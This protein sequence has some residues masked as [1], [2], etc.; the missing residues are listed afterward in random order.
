[1]RLDAGWLHN[2]IPGEPAIRHIPSSRTSKLQTTKPLAVVWH[3]TGGVAPDQAE[4]LA[5]RIRTYDRKTDRPASW[6]LIL[7]RS[8]EIWQS[9]PLSRATWHV[10]RPG[11]I[12]GKQYA[13]INRV[14]I[15]V[16]LENAGRLKRIGRDYYCWPYWLNPEDEP[17]DRKPNP[18]LIV[19]VARAARFPGVGVF[20]TFT[21]LQEETAIRLLQLCVKE[22]GWD[23]QACSYGHANFDSP[24]KEDPG[25]A[26]TMESLPKI[27]TKVFPA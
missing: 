16:E 22:Y 26:W 20:E 15:G 1:M 7:A 2:D 23:R 17:E 14:T 27:L 5:K 25:P 4:S 12:L 11:K 9:A 6:H 3:Y 8:G 21:T 18:K 24:R 10:G 19:D 13:N